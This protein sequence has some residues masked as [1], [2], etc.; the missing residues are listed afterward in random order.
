MVNLPSLK[1]GV[2]H[3]AMAFSKAFRKPPP[4]WFAFRLFSMF[5]TGCCEYASLLVAW[6]L[7]EEYEGITVDVVMGE[8]KEDPEQRHI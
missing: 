2:V 5:P 4:Q 3:S 7:S 1:Q 8:L 6:F